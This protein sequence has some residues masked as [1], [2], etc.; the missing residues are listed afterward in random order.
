MGWGFVPGTEFIGY[1]SCSAQFEDEA[2]KNGDGTDKRYWIQADP[3]PFFW[4]CD[5]VGDADDRPEFLFTLDVE[6]GICLDDRHCLCC[7]ARQPLP[8]VFAAILF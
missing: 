2:G 5:P 8:L 6:A 4:Y 1:F 7:L 3:D